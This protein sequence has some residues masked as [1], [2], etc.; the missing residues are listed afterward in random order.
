MGEDRG[1]KKRH[2]VLIADV[3]G[4]TRA[5]NLRAALGQRVE[6]AA[7]EHLKK[8]W[9][10]LPYAITAGDEFQAILGKVV[11]V[12][13]V[14][15]DLRVKLWPLQLRIGI[16]VGSVRERI[17][18]PVNRMGGEA[19]QRAR[20]AIEAIKDEH[21]R[22]EVLTAFRTGNEGFDAAANL[23]YALQDT[24]LIEM[25]RKQQDTVRAYCE[26]G[27]IGGAAKRLRLN[28]STVS[29]SLS[30]GYFWQMRD[31]AEGLGRLIVAARW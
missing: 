23:I 10:E 2:A 16:G 4:S 1:M 7:R 31:A 3:V 27:G 24:L 25:T 12:P 6:R 21:L 13:E 17:Q 30:R 20:R 14:I 22:Y 11:N 19:F 15:F 29:R 28:E 8:K 9:I 18:R 26:E 5:R